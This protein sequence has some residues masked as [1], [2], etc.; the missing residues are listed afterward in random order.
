MTVQSKKKFTSMLVL[1]KDYLPPPCTWQY[2]TLNYTWH[3]QG[4]GR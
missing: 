2:H 3:V 4:G 1:L